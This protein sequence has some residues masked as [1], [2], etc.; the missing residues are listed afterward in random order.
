MEYIPEPSVLVFREKIQL[1]HH[2]QDPPTLQ[3]KKRTE[4]LP[5]VLGVLVYSLPSIILSSGI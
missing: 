3:P 1:K 5:K 2:P 4:S